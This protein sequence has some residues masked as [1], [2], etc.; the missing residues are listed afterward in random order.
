M[1]ASA[2]VLADAIERHA[3]DQALRHRVLHDPLTGLP[4]RL[5]FVDS[6]GDALKRG[7]RLRLAG[8][9]PLPRPRP[10]Q[11]DQRQHR[12]PRR[13]RAAARGRA[14]PAR[15]PAPGRHRRPLRRRRVRDPGRSPRR[16]GRGGGDRR[17]RRRAPSPSPTRSAASST[18]SPPASASPS[19]DPPSREPIDADML[20]RDADAAMYRAKE[21]GRARCEL[22]DAEMRAR[23]VRRLEVE[24]ELRQALERDELTLHYQPVVALGS[25]EI[26]GLEALVRWHH[27]ERGLLDPGEFI[28]IAEDSGL[29]EPIGRWVQES[30]CRQMLDWHEL[31]PDQRPLDVSVNLSARQ[32]AHRDL[33]ASVAEILARTGLDPSPPAASRSPRA[34]WSR[35]RRRATATLEALSEIGVRPRPR[36]LRHRLL[37]A[38]LP[39]PL[40]LRR[41]EDRPLLRRRARGRAGAHRDRRGDHRHG[42]GALPRRDRR[43]SRERGPALRAAPPRLRLRAGPPL[44]AGAAGGEDHRACS[45]DGAARATRGSRPAGSRC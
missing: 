44:L 42:P 27:P 31:R 18:S 21:R 20:I 39:Q 15:P 45:R 16:R 11:A 40:P 33:A 28:P 17:S 14:P 30:A 6:L 41:A 19:P 13:R 38:R 9:D 29:I 23:A 1:Q 10:L 5:S 8:R 2:N 22:F 3:A 35:S 32:V 25:G 26:T 12:P 24:R 36:R 34:S 7:D 43:G 37:L 4:N